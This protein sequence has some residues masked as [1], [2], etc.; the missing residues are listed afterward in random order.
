METR[1]LHADGEKRSS[2]ISEELGALAPDSLADTL[3]ANSPRLAQANFR[4]ATLPSGLKVVFATHNEL[5]SEGQAIPLAHAFTTLPDKTLQATRV[6]VSSPVIAAGGQGCV[7]F[8]LRL[9]S[10]LAPGKRV[11]TSARGTHT[12]RSLRS[13]AA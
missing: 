2:I 4:D 13:H 12:Q 7:D 8:A 9:L 3:K 1:I 6:F 5:P 11:L 10:T